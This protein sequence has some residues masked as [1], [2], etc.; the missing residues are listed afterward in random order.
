MT[1]YNGRGE[2]AW[3]VCGEEQKNGQRTITLS[4][5]RALDKGE[6]F[7][8]PQVNSYPVLSEELSDCHRDENS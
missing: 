4:R 1:V 3:G 5:L 6:P 2:D 7:R 8:L